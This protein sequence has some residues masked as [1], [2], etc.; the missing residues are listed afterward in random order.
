MDRGVEILIGLLVICP[1]MAIL[2]FIGVWLAYKLIFNK[3]L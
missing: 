2:V 1:S 3:K